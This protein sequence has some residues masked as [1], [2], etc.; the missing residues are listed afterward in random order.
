MLRNQN[1]CSGKT[2]QNAMLS[3]V[4]FMSSCSVVSNSSW[5][6]GL[7]ALQARLSM[8]FSRQEYWSGLP[9][10]PPGD[11]PDPE[12]KPMTH[13]SCIGRWVVY[14]QHCLGNYNV[15]FIFSINGV[16]SKVLKVYL[17]ILIQPE[18]DDGFKGVGTLE[19]CRE[20]IKEEE[21]LR[22][23]ELRSHDN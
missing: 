21:M 20:Q 6:H 3:D 7:V 12:I 14:H 9:F 1:G 5:P 2:T 22:K 13:V 23:K 8:E 16:F 4:D 18:Q 17:K 19:S 10:P 11:L 15:G